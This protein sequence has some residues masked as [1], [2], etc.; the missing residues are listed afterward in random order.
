MA[1]AGDVRSVANDARWRAGRDR[2]VLWVR[3]G[4]VGHI[5]TAGVD[6]VEALDL[7]AQ[8]AY[9]RGGSAGTWGVRAKG[10]A[11]TETRRSRRTCVVAQRSRR[12]G[13]TTVEALVPEMQR[14]TDRVGALDSG[15]GDCVRARHVH[16]PGSAG[17][18][19]LRG[20]GR[21]GAVRRPWRHRRRWTH[22]L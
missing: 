1:R 20:K 10:T 11:V 8:I 21:S 2:C 17:R 14:R 3:T 7:V 15:C 18:G 19:V 5:G 16:E 22:L 13:V 4:R 9:V 12:L 6:R